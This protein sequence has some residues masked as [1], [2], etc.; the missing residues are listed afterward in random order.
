M[1]QVRTALL[2]IA[3]A[4]PGPPAAFRAPAGPS[5]V[6]RASV[7]PTAASPKPVRPRRGAAPPLATVERTRT[8]LGAPC[9]AV[10]EG[11]GDST[12]TARALD[13]ALDEIARLEDVMS[14]ERN[15][16]EITR[17]NAAAGERFTCSSDLYAVI[18]SAMGAAGETDGF[19]DPTIEPF[20]RAWDVRGDGRVPPADEIGAAR[21]LVGWRTVFR[22]PRGPTVRLP[23]PGM[24][25][26]LDVI[27]R[28]YALERLADVLLERGIARALVDFGGEIL[29]V[30]NREPWQVTVAGPGERTSPA[31]RLALTNGALSTA[32]QARPGI[33]DDDERHRLVLEP[34]TGLPVRTEAS[35]SVV[36]RSA[37]RAAALSSALLV[38]GR[39]RAAAFTAAHGGLGVLWLEP[40]EDELRAWAWN[41]PS[42]AAEPGVNI[43]WMSRP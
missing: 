31:V 5:A 30:S 22:E 38:M 26:D 21:A 13:E 24:A 29:A 33:G 25:I 3:L 42:V 15:T 37:T 6:F 7:G 12:A 35:V 39:E 23:R 16:S 28:G 43:R 32:V 18:D 2:L 9:T 40:G 8:L 4:L 41:L 1:L 19:F 20:N 27:G 34:R 36:A 10:A 17:L 14:M 11:R